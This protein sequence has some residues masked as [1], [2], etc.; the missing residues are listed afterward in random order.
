MEN[1]LPLVSVIIPCYNH[2]NYIQD[3]IQS[4]LDQTYAN[5]EL[6]VIDDGSK[7]QSVAKIEEML[8][9]CK[10]RFEYVYFNTRA[11]KGLCATLNEALQLCKG[12]YVSIIASDDIM[13]AHKTQL[14]VDYLEKNSNVMGVFGGVELI[15][16][17]GVVIGERISNQTEYSLKE[18]LLSQHDLPAL[19]QMY[20]LSCIK[21]IGGYDENIKIEDWDLILRLIKNNKKLK[22]IPEKVAKYRIHEENFSKNSLKMSIEMLKV[23]QKF[24][25]EKLYSYVQYRLNRIVLR[26][27]LKQNSL[28][29][30]YG[31]KARNWLKYILTKL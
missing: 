15:N 25:D 17:S 31:M 30:Y 12:K 14:Q 13:L 26:E 11:N 28:I 27:T 4:V 19:T 18:V 2:Q 29:K 9:Q 16:K 8:E 21:N 10:A 22:Y 3:S 1:R 23:L 6:I 7:D 20:H 5:I 24:S